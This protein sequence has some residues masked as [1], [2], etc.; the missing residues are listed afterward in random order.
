VTPINVDCFE[1]FFSDPPAIT[2]LAGD[3]QEGVLTLHQHQPSSN[4]S[5]SVK[6]HLF[7]LPN[8]LT[9]LNVYK[10]DTWTIDEILQDRAKAKTATLDGNDAK[11]FND[12]F[13]KGKK[14]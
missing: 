11:E 4:G 10:W 3:F 13:G 14:I 12:W 6:A 1:I 2:M 5:Q 8:T 9:K 7:A